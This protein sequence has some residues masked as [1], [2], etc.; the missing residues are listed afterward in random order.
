MS[1]LIF[2]RIWCL[3]VSAF[4]DV[5]ARNVR[6][7]VASY[8]G[9]TAGFEVV[10]G[11]V[12]RVMTLVQVRHRPFSIF[13]AF[14]HSPLSPISQLTLGDMYIYRAFSARQRAFTWPES[15]LR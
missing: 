3:G 5:G 6:R 4:S 14:S 9:L 7:M 10:H 2:M 8:T 12:D 11:L 15:I 1:S 13:T